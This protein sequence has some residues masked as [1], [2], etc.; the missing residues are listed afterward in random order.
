[1]LRPYGF[2]GSFPPMIIVLLVLALIFDFLN[3]F[4]DS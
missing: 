2:S 3:G 1:M 4:H